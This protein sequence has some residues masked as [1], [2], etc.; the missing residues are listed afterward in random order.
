[1]SE[2]ESKLKTAEAAH[3]AAVAGTEAAQQESQ[4]AVT[5]MEEDLAALREELDSEK[6]ARAELLAVA[7]EHEARAV[8]AEGEAASLQEQLDVSQAAG[9]AAGS[10]DDD[11]AT[12]ERVS[13]LESKLKTAEA[14]HAAA[15][16]GTEAARQENV[17]TA[18]ERET[19]PTSSRLLFCW[20][21][22]VAPGQASGAAAAPQGAT[23]LHDD[24]EF[25]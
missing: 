21:S 12:A 13:E 19:T 1:M 5:F 2:L 15:V 20:S 24:E 4:D 9:S 25:C 3:A 16:A 23:E 6:A 22:N 17:E 10:A 14:A 11:S 8:A 7:S 18:V